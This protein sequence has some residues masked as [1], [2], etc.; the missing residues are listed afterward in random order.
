MPKRI[1][2]RVLL[3]TTEAAEIS[4]LGRVHIARLLRAELIEGIK[5]GHDW[6]VFEDSL[7]AYLT[8]PRKTGPK[9]KG[10]DTQTAP[11]G[12]VSSSTHTNHDDYHHNPESGKS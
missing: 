12:S 1:G 4:K 8:Q 3:S 2:E 9:P 6:L 11:D 5:L 7:K 10:K